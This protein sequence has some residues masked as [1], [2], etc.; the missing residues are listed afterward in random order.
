MATRLKRP[1][2]PATRSIDLKQH[3]MRWEKK[4]HIYRPEGNEAWSKSHAQVPF[5]YDLDESTI[6]V[7]YATRDDRSRS[8]VSFV[9]LDKSNPQQIK[10]RHDKPCIIHGQPG[11][12]DDSGVMPSWFVDHDDEIWMYYTG[13]NTSSSASY[14]LSIGLAVSRD[15]GVTF[16]RKFEGPVLD[17]GMHD[18]IW[19]G[20]P[21]VLKEG[22][23]WKMWYLSCQKIS[24]VNEH[25]EPHYNV[26]YATSSDGMHWH[27]T[28]DTCIDFDERTD[29][30]GRPCV[31]K[32]GGKYFMLHSNR[33]SVGY[34]EDK[35]ESYRIELSA[36]EDGVEW[37]NISDRFQFE[38]SD[39]GWDSQMN[40]YCTI[41]PVGDKTLMFYNGNGFGASGFGYAELYF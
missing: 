10:Y 15:R 11:D 22:D 29:A 20:Q 18:P 8:S 6:R 5:A 25:P 31:W 17:R 37:T 1:T 2:N 13:W 32:D 30:I 40:E 7:F 35:S 39:E 19:V 26:K 33:M 23:E 27:R 28:E 41:L 34:R 24:Q 9:D 36:S 16:E 3:A 38:K 21:C 14:R 12:F 4:G